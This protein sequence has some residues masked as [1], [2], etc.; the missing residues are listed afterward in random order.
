MSGA[1]P[2]LWKLGPLHTTARQS[3]HVRSRSSHSHTHSSQKMCLQLSM[4]APLKSSWQIAHVSP[5]FSAT[6]ASVANRP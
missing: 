4:T 5:V 3:G 1:L 2:S 6:S